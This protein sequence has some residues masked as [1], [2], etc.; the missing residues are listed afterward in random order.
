[1]SKFRKSLR[2]K[3]EDLIPVQGIL[4]KLFNDLDLEKKSMDYMIMLA[5]NDYARQKLSPSIS[6]S[7]SAH[8]INKNRNLVIA[9]KSA[10]IVQELQFL[11]GKIEKEFLE[12]IREI[13]SKIKGL[14]FELR[15]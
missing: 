15:S 6:S 2:P 5:W 10:V 11:K 4:G 7:T 14:S 8:R 13:P 9:V 1:M 3:Q 12:F